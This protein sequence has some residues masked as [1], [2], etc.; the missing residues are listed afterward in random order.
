MAKEQK[1]S[2][3]HARLL[4][5]AK[6]LLRHLGWAD[7]DLDSEEHAMVV[8]EVVEALVQAANVGRE[9]ALDE[10]HKQGW[11]DLKKEMRAC[12]CLED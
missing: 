2:K 7:A 9:E 1:P 5:E 4:V 10:G 6:A 12:R 11:A 8:K 3:F